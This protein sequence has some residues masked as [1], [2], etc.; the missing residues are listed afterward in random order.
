MVE[1]SL[2]EFCLLNLDCTIHTSSKKHG[3]LIYNKN[4]DLVTKLCELI[5]SKTDE[6]SNDSL[7]STA[8]K[9]CKVRSDKMFHVVRELRKR[10]KE[11]K[12]LPQ[13]YGKYPELLQSVSL[14][15]LVF[16]RTKIEF[17]DDSKSEEHIPLVDPLLLNCFYYLIC[18]EKDA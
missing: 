7:Y 5:A 1:N 13:M 8:S 2:Q 14:K 18:P 12:K 4:W 11:D 3:R 15:N 9:I 17:T 6:S 16:C 10:L